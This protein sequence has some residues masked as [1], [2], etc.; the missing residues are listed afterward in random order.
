GFAVGQPVVV[1]GVSGTLKVAA[2]GSSVYGPGTA[3]ILSGG[4]VTPAT[5][6]SGTVASVRI[7]G[8][9]ITITGGGGPSSPL[10]VYGDP[11]QDRVRSS[12]DPTAQTIRDFGPK[13]F[14]S[15]LGN[16]TPHYFMPVGIP[17]QY[18]GNDVI[19]ASALFANTPKSQLPTVGLTIYG[20]PG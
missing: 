19:D 1:P 16:G 13:P 7:G 5:N 2:F 4:N 3:L 11:S 6:V 18:A 9:I 12:G 17:F 15:I 10:V 8:D 14:P 20:G